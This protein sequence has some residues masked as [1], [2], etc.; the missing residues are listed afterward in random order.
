VSIPRF[1]QFERDALLILI[2]G[3]HGQVNRAHAARAD[4]ADEFVGADLPPDHRVEFLRDG[5][6][7]QQRSA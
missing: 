7:V 1:D 6:V 5:L 4:F 3:A 2:I